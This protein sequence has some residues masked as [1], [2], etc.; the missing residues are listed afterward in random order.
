MEKIVVF[1]DN[2]FLIR[3]KSSFFKRKFKYN[4]KQFIINLARKNNLF[5]EEI[6]LY[7][8][9]PYQ[10]EIPNEKEKRMKEKYDK[11][12]AI[13][14]NQGIVVREG[15]TQRLKMNETFVY[16]QKGVDMIMG[17]DAISVKEDFRDVRK[18]ILVTGDSDFVPLVKKLK[19]QKISVFLWTYFNRDRKSPFSKSN[20]LV[21]SVSDYLKITKADFL[22]VEE[23]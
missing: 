17:I 21:K 19:E 5:V 10:S 22:E 23:K 15:R 20:E 2:A 13:F 9:P 12:L 4:L 18:I 11:Y 14:K 3:L 6:F 16:N 8:A 1:I 7:D